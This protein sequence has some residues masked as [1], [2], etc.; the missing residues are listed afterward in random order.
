MP[1]KTKV[2][3]EM[4][5]KGAFELVKRDGID[6]LSAKNLAKELSCSTQPLF[7]WYANMEEI[8][9]VVLA[10]ANSMFEECLKSGDDGANPYKAIG[11][12]YI[13]FAKEQ[14]QL[15]K[16][17]FMSDNNGR[18]VLSSIEQMPFILDA[19]NTQSVMD[20]ECS[21][22]VMREMWLFAHGI[23]TM[24]A[25]DTAQFEQEDVNRMLSDVFKGLLNNYGEKPYKNE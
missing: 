12:N 11:I 3:R 20:K 21:R 2:S 15:F 14:K 18:D 24:T 5:A 17:L 25:T 4:I 19:L 13:R 10:R 7:W 8:K 22:I 1:P 6:A 16:A 23:A 9:S